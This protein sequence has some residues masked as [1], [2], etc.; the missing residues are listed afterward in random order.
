M[1][2]IK[3]NSTQQICPNDHNS[4]GL[5]SRMS[6]SPLR[7]IIIRSKQNRLRVSKLTLGKWLKRP[8]MDL[9]R[10]RWTS[11]KTFRWATVKTPEIRI[12]NF[13]LQRSSQVYPNLHKGAKVRLGHILIKIATSKSLWT[14]KNRTQAQ[15]L[16]KQELNS[17]LRLWHQAKLWKRSKSTCLVSNKLMKMLLNKSD[18]LWIAIQE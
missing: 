14:F 4:L 9:L 6:G 18:N 7:I 17:I 5:D 1:T 3:Q 15:E 11:E 8:Q 13:N 10:V 2:I 12:I 16:D